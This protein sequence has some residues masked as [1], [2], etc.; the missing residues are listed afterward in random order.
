MKRTLILLGGP[1]VLST[2]SSNTSSR[3]T[4]STYT[5]DKNMQILSQKTQAL[6]TLFS[7]TSKLWPSATRHCPSTWGHQKVCCPDT[8]AAPSPSA[9]NTPYICSQLPWKTSFRKDAVKPLYIFLINTLLSW[10]YLPVWTYRSFSILWD[11]QV[12][13]AAWYQVT[14]AVL[15]G[16]VQGKTVPREAHQLG[17]DPHLQTDETGSRRPV[18]GLRHL[19]TQLSVP[20]DRRQ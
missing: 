18:L 4:S 3:L 1:A 16:V 20:A 9:H 19:H 15:V 12:V 13:S 2:S 11:V 6:K 8:G 17:C 10:H 7:N 5:R 14:P